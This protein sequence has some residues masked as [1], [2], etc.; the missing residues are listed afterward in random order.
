MHAG[1][2]LCATSAWS[3]LQAS[4][5]RLR[6]QLLLPGP[7]PPINGLPVLKELSTQRFRLI[8]LRGQTSIWRAALGCLLEP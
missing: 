7:R 8:H 1:G 2:A 6:A 3:S 4:S 5:T